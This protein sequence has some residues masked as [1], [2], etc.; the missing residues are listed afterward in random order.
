[1]PGGRPT[2]YTDDM[3]QKV[4]D[5]L[6]GLQDGNEELLDDEGK[7]IRIRIKVNL[8]GVSALASFLGVARSTLYLWAED[9]EEFSDTLDRI[10]DEQEQRLIDH[11]LSGEYNSTIAKLMLSSNHGHKE[12]SDHTS[13][14]KPITM[15]GFLNNLNGDTERGE[16]KASG[17]KVEGKQ[18][19]QD[20]GQAG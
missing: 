10:K 18:P 12:R 20:N 6:E 13:D 19:V 9:H 16:D 14:D 7:L 11:G 3:P 17:Q 5:W 2:D 15:S 4:L 1:M 8:P